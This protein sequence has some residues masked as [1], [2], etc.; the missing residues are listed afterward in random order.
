MYASLVK[1]AAAT[2][3]DF[4]LDVLRAIGGA[5]KESLTSIDQALSSVAGAASVWSVSDLNNGIFRAPC[6][7]A[8][9]SKV[10]RLA[11]SGGELKL[12]AFHAWSDVA[13]SGE[14]ETSPVAVADVSS[15]RV[16]LVVTPELVAISGGAWGTKFGV[17][18]EVHEDFPSVM[19]GSCWGVLGAGFVPI[20]PLVKNGISD[21]Y[22]ANVSANTISSG[23]QVGRG[24][25][26]VTFY[27][28]VSIMLVTT[29]APAAPG[30][31]G[32]MRGMWLT[33]TSLGAGGLLAADTGEIYLAMK[34]SGSSPVIV[35]ERK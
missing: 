24:V 5:T 1:S 9:R 22:T 26:E 10:F 3:S 34:K 33:A 17:A 11:S 14:F 31:F 12:S 23:L 18:Y 8:A 25:G 7:N 19:A 20:F 32:Y 4:L 28:L 21:G 6:L 15:G 27:P 35:V 16:Y 29:A 30:W 13:H 2:D